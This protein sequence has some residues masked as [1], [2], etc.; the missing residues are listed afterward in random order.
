MYKP[1]KEDLDKLNRD[2]L[3]HI[4]NEAKDFLGYT[5]EE[6]N[7]ITQR[8]LSF[9]SIFLSLVSVASGYAFVN[10]E[11]KDLKLYMVFG[12]VLILFGFMFY[13]FRIIFPREIYT[14]G[15]EPNKMFIEERL[16]TP[17]VSIEHNFTIIIINE[18]SSVQNKIQK[19]KER[20]MKRIIYLKHVLLFSPIILLI[21]TIVCFF[22]LIK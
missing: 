14:R 18:I 1:K 13:L 11:K 7:K 10:I 5:I 4:L 21:Y 19:N 15:R 9:F 8:A 22:L 6:S 3:I 12:L 20:N 16:F 2:S 17:D